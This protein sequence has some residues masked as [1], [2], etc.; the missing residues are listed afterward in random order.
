M[1]STPV[2]VQMAEGKLFRRCGEMAEAVDLLGVGSALRN[3]DQDGVQIRA[4]SA[5]EKETR[6]MPLELQVLQVVVVPGEIERDIV[7]AEERVPIADQPRMIAVQS[8]G[9]N[10]VVAHRD[11]VRR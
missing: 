8:V 11:Q 5:G 4:A 2:L 6:R 1:D 3:I 7:F 10:G 9:V